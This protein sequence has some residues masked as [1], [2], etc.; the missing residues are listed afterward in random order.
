MKRASIIAVIVA[1]AFLT[2]SS[3]N[4]V[5]AQNTPVGYWRATAYNDNTP[6]LPQIGMQHICFLNNG[7]WWG[8]SPG[9]RGRWFQKGN[10]ASGNG[11][12][13]RM[14]G[15]FAGGSGNDGAEMDFVHLR[16][17]T[18]PWSEFYDVPSGVGGFLL[19]LRVELVFAQSTCPPQPPQVAP[20]GEREERRAPF[21]GSNTGGEPDTRP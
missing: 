14:V 18:G 6:S 10:N 17:M 20:R 19:W 8:T 7:T 13:V 16:L 3:A 1:T 12:R 11:D 21:G 15:N 9:W 5:L 2:L 4:Q